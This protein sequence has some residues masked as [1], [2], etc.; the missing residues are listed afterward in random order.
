MAMT[1]RPEQMPSFGRL[2][3]VELR[4]A[5]ASE[6]TGFTPWLAE[7]DNL[8]L[9]AETLGLNLEVEAIERPVGPFRAD[10]LCRDLDTGSWVLIENQIERTDHTHLGQILTYAAGLSAA[11]IVWV[12]AR[13]TAEHRAALDWLNTISQDEFAFF[14]VEV[15]LWRIAASL[16]APRFNIVSKPNAWSRAVAKTAQRAARGEPEGIDVNRVAYWSAFAERLAEHDGPLK[17]RREPPRLG[18]YSFTIDAKKSCYLYAY[19][20]VDK[21]RIGVYVAFYGPDSRRFFEQ[22]SADREEIE[23]RIGDKPWWEEVQPDR[24]YYIGLLLDNADALDEA[25]WP[26]QHDWL[27]SR[28]DRLY[29]TLAPRIAILTPAAVAMSETA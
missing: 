20:L 24:K 4:D 27:V 10:I 2:E 12:S 8:A 6:A 18:Y 25:D 17:P 15:E 28:L 23:Q 5:W 11:V 14:G 16:P 26:R 1:T 21:Q 13:F 7:A 3:S 29:T 22:L 19:R 9:L